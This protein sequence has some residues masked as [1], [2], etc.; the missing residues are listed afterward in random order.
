MFDKI[1]YFV[2][3]YIN[4]STVNIVI[5]TTVTHGNRKIEYV[6]SIDDYMAS[7]SILDDFTYDF[8]VGEIES[9][10]IFMIKTLYF[11]N[12]DNLCEQMKTDLDE[13]TKLKKV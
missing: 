11:D 13:F 12:S 8:F 5:E 1:I 2:N 7:I 3:S 6:L 9:E 10:N 4:E